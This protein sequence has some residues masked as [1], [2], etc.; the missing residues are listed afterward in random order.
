[1]R[2]SPIGQVPITGNSTMLISTNYAEGGAPEGD[3]F[4][5]IFVNGKLKRTLEVASE[6]STS[7]RYS[8]LNE[9]L[10]LIS[11]YESYDTGDEVTVVDTV[12]LKWI[13]EEY[14]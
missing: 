2:F 7:Y 12:H 3:V 8:E 13:A 6:F 4:G 10:V 14:E 5:Y 1:M 9:D 11:N